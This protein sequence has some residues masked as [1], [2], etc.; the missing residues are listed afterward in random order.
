M[1]R[2]VTSPRAVQHNLG[3][4]VQRNARNVQ[5]DPVDGTPGRDVKGFQVLVPPCKVCRKLRGRNNPHPLSLRVQHPDSSFAGD[6]Y[7]SLRVHL[8]A[9]RRQGY[10]RNQSKY[11]AVAS[12]SV[13]GYVEYADVIPFGIRDIK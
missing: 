11:A 13:T 1:I 3:Q 12:Y 6:I 4:S 5:T 9:V 7:I 10:L 8:E 2:I